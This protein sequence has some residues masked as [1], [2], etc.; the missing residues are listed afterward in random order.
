MTHTSH[1]ETRTSLRYWSSISILN[2][3]PWGRRVMK[4]SIHKWLQNFSKF[5]FDLM[6]HHTNELKDPILSL[7]NNL[8]AIILWILQIT[9]LGLSLHMFQTPHFVVEL[10]LVMITCFTAVILGWINAC[11]VL[12]NTILVVIVPWTLNKIFRKFT[13]RGSSI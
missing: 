9:Q 4:W 10:V 5:N 2:P 7:K 12:V 11:K 8:K 13:V 3:L 6:M 1:Y